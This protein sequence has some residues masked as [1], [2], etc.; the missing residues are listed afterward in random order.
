MKEVHLW[1]FPLAF[2]W[3][4]LSECSNFCP[5]LKRQKN[6]Q[7]EMT[8]TWATSTYYGCSV[9]HWHSS[10]SSY[11]SI[12]TVKLLYYE[13]KNSSSGISVLFLLQQ[14]AKTW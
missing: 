9:V 14:V 10:H 2:L 8:D 6:D 1:A 11:F 4:F 12:F 13:G 3:D 5:D 7:V